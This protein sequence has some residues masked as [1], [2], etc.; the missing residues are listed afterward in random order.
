[1]REGLP[2]LYGW[3]WYPW[4]RKFFESRN[5]FCLLT[6][7]NQA[8]KS[9]T[10]IRK[11]IHWSTETDQWSRLWR[12]RPSQFWYMYPGADVATAEF[13][14]KWVTQ[15]MPRGEF[16]RH[17]KYGWK[18]VFKQQQIRSINWNNGLISYF[19]NYTQKPAVLQTATV[20]L[21]AAD[22][23]MPMAI[24]DEI[25]TRLTATSGYFWSVFT[26]TIGQD[27]WR[28]AMEPE[29][30]EKEFLPEAHKQTVSLYDCLNYEDGSRSHWTT[31]EI[32]SIED[33]CSSHDE[34]LKRVHGRFI[35]LAKGR[36]YPTFDMKKH[37]KGSGPIPHDWEIYAA[38]DLGSGGEGNHPAAIV[39]I[40]V[41]PE[42]TLGRVFKAWRGDGVVTSAGDVFLKFLEMKAEIGRPITAQ[43]YDFGGKD[44]DIISTRAGDGFIKADKSHDRGEHVVN[45]VFKFGMLTIDD[46][47]EELRKL[48]IEL[49]MLPKD[50][51][52]KKKKDDLSDACRYCCVG[53]PWDF[54]K[55]TLPAEQPGDTD[56]RKE[57][58]RSENRW[59]EA[60]VV[61]HTFDDKDAPE[62]EI[63]DQI[64]E[65]N[66]LLGY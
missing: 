49:S 66:D 60:I 4:A 1:M 47:D 63:H 35:K 19:K 65:I 43:W 31:K 41:N 55:I 32:K 52:R 21:V 14:T 6:A 56:E 59:G 44:F 54:S 8:S 64:A 57:E 17:P 39:F 20:S 28:L 16:E 2:H 12:S 38:V 58:S 48:A 61:R 13:E 62:Q 25:K 45:T 26:A 50:G 7:A 27:E 18:A 24:Y 40:A 10:M 9:S 51:P 3:P 11:Y 36:K 29:D 46:S 15:F 34:V 33:S 30:G 53:I 42:H 5:R 23:E 37:H 22:E